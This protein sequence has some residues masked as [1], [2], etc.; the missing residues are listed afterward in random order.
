MNTT[1]YR[2][3]T[4]HFVQFREP[5]AADDWTFAGPKAAGH[6]CFGPDSP[7]D[8][9]GM[10]T[11]VSD[12]W[13][14]VA[15]YTDPEAAAGT[16][17]AIGENLDFLADAR[18]S[19]HAH[20]CPIAHRGAVNWFEK[21]G[22]DAAIVPADQDPGGLLTVITTAGFNNLPPE[23]LNADLPRRADLLHNVDRVRDW[24]GT[25]PANLA[26]GVFGVSPLGNDG[27]TFSVWQ[28]DAAMLA[29]AYRP[30]TH[31]TQ[32][33]RYKREQTADRTSFTRTPLLKSV[34][35]WDGEWRSADLPST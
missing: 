29:T 16:I 9:N 22:Q 19:W 12:V 31:R 33:D 21:A 20:L 5:R 10:R 1:Q 6:W 35:S 24:F 11:R 18:Q 28:D 17:E 8:E 23:E 30:G 34:G 14:G 27:M 25:L 15:F 7:Q 13:G 2:A 3:I 26:R 4:F 32:I